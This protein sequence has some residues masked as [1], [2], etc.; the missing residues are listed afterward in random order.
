MNKIKYKGTKEGCT[1]SKL[2]KQLLIY[3]RGRQGQPVLGAELKQR[4][5]V[6]NL[7]TENYKLKTGNALTLPSDS[8]CICC[9]QIWTDLDLRIGFAASTK[10]TAVPLKTLITILQFHSQCSIK[11][12]EKQ[13]QVSNEKRWIERARLRDQCHPHRGQLLGSR[14]M[15]CH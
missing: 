5:T 2:P 4:Q 13:L 12:D 8:H 6:I 7:K 1:P 3:S 10:C 11:S 14:A 15:N 9:Q